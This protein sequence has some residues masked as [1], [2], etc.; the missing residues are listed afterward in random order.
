MYAN[1][2]CF[3]IT[4][5]DDQIVVIREDETFYGVSLRRFHLGTE[6]YPDRLIPPYNYR[7][8]DEY[9]SLEPTYYLKSLEIMNNRTIPIFGSR[10]LLYQRLHFFDRHRHTAFGSSALRHLRGDIPGIRAF[11]HLA[12]AD[13]EQIPC[14]HENR[15]YT[16]HQKLDSLRT[17]QFFSLDR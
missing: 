8:S 15:C 6:G 3:R 14:R 13:Q 10:C 1:P 16:G 9:K 12:V 7:D 11:L 5:H 17:R 4:Q 2:Q